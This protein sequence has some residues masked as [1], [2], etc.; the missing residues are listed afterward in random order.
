ML[1]LGIRGMSEASATY[2][3]ANPCLS[4]A[5]IVGLAGGERA[6]QLAPYNVPVEAV[7][8]AAVQES[9]MAVG[10][11]IVLDNRRSAW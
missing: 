5:R 2:R 7:R 8:P 3:F 10:A 9:R 4:R 6:R 1:V 11:G